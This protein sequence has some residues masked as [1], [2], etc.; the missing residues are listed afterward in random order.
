VQG[1]VGASRQPGL[2]AARLA[3]ESLAL[4][5][6]N[7]EPRAEAVRFSAFSALVYLSEILLRHEGLNTS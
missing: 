3:V 6:R 4:L 5:L 1:H 2:R 7:Q